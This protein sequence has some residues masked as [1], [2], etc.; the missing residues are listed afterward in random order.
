MQSAKGFGRY[1]I[2]IYLTDSLI[3]LRAYLMGT[4]GGGVLV[5][6]LKEVEVEAD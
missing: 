1:S 6:S 4:G 3:D 5:S 2:E